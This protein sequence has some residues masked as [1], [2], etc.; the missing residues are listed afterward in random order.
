MLYKVLGNF[1]NQKKFKWRSSAKSSQTCT[2]LRCTEQSGV[3]QTVSGARL[4]HPVNMPLSGK[5]QGAAA[6]IHRI[7]RPVWQSCA[8]L[9]VGHAINGHH[10]CPA[11]GHQAALDCSM[12]HGTRGWQWSALLNK[13][14]NR[15]LFTVRWWCTRLSGAPTDRRQSEPSKWSSNDF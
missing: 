12:C 4:A 9:T 7:V 15:A 3:H 2:S 1:S 8:Q 13:E 11:N 5:R 6:I 14:G 10:V